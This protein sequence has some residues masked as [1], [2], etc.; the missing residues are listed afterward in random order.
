MANYF[1]PFLALLQKLV[2]DAGQ[3]GRGRRQDAA[4]LY[5]SVADAV[6]ELVDATGELQALLASAVEKDGLLIPVGYQGNPSDPVLRIMR[7]CTTLQA[8]L[9]RS[10]P[11]HPSLHRLHGWHDPVMFGPFAIHDLL[12][13]IHPDFD[14]TRQ[15]DWYEFVPNWLDRRPDADFH[16]RSLIFKSVY[17]EAFRVR[18]KLTEIAAD[19]RATGALLK[20]GLEKP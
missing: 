5:I 16:K 1:V 15:L 14:S 8:L 11:N 7:A 3:A 17:Q 10:M 20:S 13:R 18:L 19:L 9:G 2:S 6:Q 4:T 12:R